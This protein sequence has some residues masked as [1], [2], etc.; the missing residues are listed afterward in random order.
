[1]TLPKNGNGLKTKVITIALSVIGVLIMALATIFWQRV[2]ANEQDVEDM[3]RRVAAQLVI[4]YVRLGRMEVR[5]Q[6]DSST[7]VE[8]RADVKAILEEVR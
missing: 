5:G 8:V 1:M 7:L 4:I 6:A 2:E 3:D